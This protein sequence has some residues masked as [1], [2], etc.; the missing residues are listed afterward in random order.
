MSL[1]NRLLPFL[2][3]LL[4]LAA[5]GTAVGFAARRMAVTWD[6]GARYSDQVDRVADFGSALRALEGDTQ[7]EA[8]KLLER[9][10]STSLMLADEMRA[11]GAHG[12]FLGLLA[13][14]R[15]AGVRAAEA[16][17]AAHPLEAGDAERATRL[18]EDLCR[19]ISPGSK[20]RGLCD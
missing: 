19:Q 9:G 3:F 10:L 5:G 1:R 16:Y 13:G 11:Q 7:S 12:P 14:D 17:A 4:G 18:R 15:I 8:R 2:W 20:Y 6:L